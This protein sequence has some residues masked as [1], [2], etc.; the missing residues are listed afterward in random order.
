MHSPTRTAQRAVH[1]QY[2][3][4]SEY[5][6]FD[7]ISHGHAQS[8]GSKC[9]NLCEP[10]HQQKSR[11]CRFGLFLFCSC[12]SKAQ[13]KGNI[14]HTK[15]SISD[16]VDV[17]SESGI[18]RLRSARTSI[19]LALWYRY[20][21]LL[22]PRRLTWTKHTAGASQIFSDES[23]FRLTHGF[24]SEQ[25]N[26]KER[27][28]KV[29]NTNPCFVPCNQSPF[30]SHLFIGTRSPTSSSWDIVENL[31]LNLAC[32]TASPSS[33]KVIYTRFSAYS[34]SSLTKN[35]AH[36]S[37]C[38]ATCSRVGLHA[39]WGL[40]QHQKWYLATPN[41]A[42]RILRS[43]NSNFTQFEVLGNTKN[44]TQQQQWWQSGVWS[45]YHTPPECVIPHP[46]QLALW[47]AIALVTI[48]WHVRKL[49]L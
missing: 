47:L 8:S 36:P 30:H 34:R 12:V 6:R 21:C 28:N 4:E 19:K 43:R 33:R 23:S 29:F 31:F 22:F 49:R 45:R 15:F 44:G 27:K 41:L 5:E 10:K 2:C 42:K 20:A 32:F 3:V 11:P 17:S 39:V 46:V 1:S 14:S 16:D 7:C 26:K 18:W 13:C 9:N 40:W 38:L 48:T 25:F 35:L 37:P 24:S